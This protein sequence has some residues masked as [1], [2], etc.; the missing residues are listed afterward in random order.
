MSSSYEVIR[1]I[2]REGRKA[3]CFNSPTAVVLDTKGRLLVSEIGNDRIQ[4]NIEY[5]I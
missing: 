1:S 2:G 4:V 5:R 3:G